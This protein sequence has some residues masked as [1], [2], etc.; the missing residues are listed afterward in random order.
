M[1]L[2]G[3]KIQGVFKCRGNK[4]LTFFQLFFQSI[5]GFMTEY[6]LNPN[7]CHVLESNSR[8]VND[9]WDV[10]KKIFHVSYFKFWS[11]QRYV[12][13]LLVL[14]ELCMYLHLFI[15]GIFHCI[16]NLRLI[17]TAVF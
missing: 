12:H 15:S 10:W 14:L 3:I 1:L 17:V 13:Q 4:A 2:L 9:G 6:M 16:L 7:T 11:Y 8:M 5:V